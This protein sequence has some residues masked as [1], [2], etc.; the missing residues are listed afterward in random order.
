ML[1]NRTILPPGCQHAWT[2]RHGLGWVAYMWQVNQ[3]THAKCL[4]WRIPENFRLMKNKDGTVELAWSAPGVVFQVCPNVMIDPPKTWDKFNRKLESLLETN[5]KTNWSKAKKGGQ[6]DFKES[7]TVVLVGAG[8]VS[9]GDLETLEKLRDNVC[10]VTF[11]RAQRDYI[12]GHYYMGMEPESWHMGNLPDKD[13]KDAYQQTIAHLDLSVYPEVA[14]MPWRFSTWWGSRWGHKLGI[15]MYHS[16]PNVT[17]CALQF[18]AKTLKAKRV[19]MLGIEH[20]LFVAASDQKMKF[21]YYEAK[22]SI[23]AACWWLYRAGVDVWNCTSHTTV[24]NG[25]ILGSLDQALEYC[26]IK[27]DNA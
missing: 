7:E 11:G 26:K 12:A 24:T 6:L 16:G 10:I 21:T 27:G 2:A 14:K 4:F 23:E 15:P 22:I 9:P 8:N 25:V 19:F 13:Q 18:A 5:M 17:F 3:K 20:P 1:D